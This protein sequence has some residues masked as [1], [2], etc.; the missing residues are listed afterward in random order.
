M[1][2]RA[3][4]IFITCDAIPSLQVVSLSANLDVH[5]TMLAFFP[6]KAVYLYPLWLLTGGGILMTIAYLYYQT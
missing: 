6:S 5:M 2:E 4:A 1:N 3:I